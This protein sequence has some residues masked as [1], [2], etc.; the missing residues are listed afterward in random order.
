MESEDVGV[1][2]AAIQRCWGSEHEVSDDEVFAIAKHQWKGAKGADDSVRN[3]VVQVVACRLEEQLLMWLLQCHATDALED[4][5]KLFAACS[6]PFF[7]KDGVRPILVPMLGALLTAAVV[8]AAACDPTGEDRMDGIVGMMETNGGL[9]SKTR[10][11]I[12]SLVNCA[13]ENEDAAVW[14]QFLKLPYVLDSRLSNSRNGR[15]FMDEAGQVIALQQIELAAVRGSVEERNSMEL[16]GMEQKPVAD[17]FWDLAEQLVTLSSKADSN[18]VAQHRS[19]A[20]PETI[21][22]TL[23][24]VRCTADLEEYLSANVSIP[25]PRINSAATDHEEFDDS[26]IEVSAMK[27]LSSTCFSLPSEGSSISSELLERVFEELSAVKHLDVLPIHASFLLGLQIQSKFCFV[28]HCE[29]VKDDFERRVRRLFNRLT[30][31]NDGAEDKAWTLLERELQQTLLDISSNQNSF[32]RESQNVVSFLQSLVGVST[33]VSSKRGPAVMTISKLLDAVLIPLCSTLDDKSISAQIVLNLYTLILELFDKFVETR[34]ELDISPAA[35]QS[36]FNHVVATLCCP[37]FSDLGF[38]VLLRENLLLLLKDIMEMS[39]FAP[40]VMFA[41]LSPAI[42][43]LISL[44]NSELSNDDSCEGLEDVVAVEAYMQEVSVK[45]SLPPLPLPSVISSVQ[46]LIWGLLWDSTLSGSVS[47]ES[48]KDETWSLLDRIA[49]HEF[50]GSEFT[51]QPVKGSLLIQSAVAEMMLECGSGLFQ[52]LYDNVIPYLL[53]YEP[54]D[55]RFT[56]GECLSIPEWA[57]GKLP[58]KPEF[59]LRMSCQSLSTHSIMR[60]VA[61]CWC[62]SGAV[63]V[64]PVT[65]LN[66]LLV[67]SFGHVLAAH[68]QAVTSSQRS[69]SGTL[70]CVRWLCFLVSASY[71]LHLDTTWAWSTIR[72]Q[73]ELSLLRVLHQLDQLKGTSTSEAH[74]SQYFVAAWLAYLPAGQFEQVF[75]FIATRTNK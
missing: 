8:R 71:E 69:L 45:T 75:N 4:M 7:T 36:L 26:D 27:E 42:W 18:E 38:G 52:I 41:P 14:M 1:A 22:R 16:N 62:L 64:Q 5:S 63:N 55:A 21:A 10:C 3:F 72:T 47:L 46:V 31:W 33:K 23:N 29:S 56:E 19:A 74:F 11:V 66:V 25:D 17:V 35:L 60:Y 30:D 13:A 48:T 67:G 61:K 49:G 34:A 43:T 70:L 40:T 68:D 6:D 15:S 59:E 51:E 24:V 57:A 20:V 53:Q 73:I 12:G 9:G 28:D 44:F 50:S 54:I 58:E 65:T 2:V 39:D 32:D 37:G